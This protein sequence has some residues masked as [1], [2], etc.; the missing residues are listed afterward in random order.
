MNDQLNLIPECVSFM[1]SYSW[2]SS[3]NVYIV[4][5]ELVNTRLLKI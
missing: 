1:K 3:Y 4:F 2:I 5:L